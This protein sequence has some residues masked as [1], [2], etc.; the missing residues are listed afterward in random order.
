MSQQIKN[1][2]GLTRNIP[3]DVKREVRQNCGFGCVI[4]GLFLYQ[5]DHVDPSW[6]ESK[7]H[8]PN[9]MCLLCPNH[10]TRKTE[11]SISLDDIKLACKNPKAKE[12]S[13]SRDNEFYS[14]KK[15]NKIRLGNWVFNN[16]KEI[17]K[18]GGK[19]LLALEETEDGTIALTGQFY[20][21]NSK[22]ILKIDKNEWQPLTGNW[23]VERVN[24]KL[25]IREKD[26]QISLTVIIEPQNL[27]VFDDIKMH[28]GDIY[29]VSSGGKKIEIYYKNKLVLQHDPAEEG[30]GIETDGFLEISSDGKLCPIKGRTTIGKGI[31][32]IGNL[33]RLESSNHECDI[34]ELTTKVGRND[35]CPCGAINPATGEVFKWKKCGMINAPQHRKSLIN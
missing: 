18:I 31:L 32:T 23:D 8:D 26:R 10:H 16:P 20:D 7:I 12:V 6:T 29:L 13:Y 15:P 24:K 11:K 30:K 17:L 28:Y 1:K 21:R 25:T 5:Y 34:I 22:L 4:C 2:Y 19:I 9:A 3:S 27:L 33:G 35:P 14:I